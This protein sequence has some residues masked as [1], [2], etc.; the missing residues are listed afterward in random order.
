IYHPEAGATN[1]LQSYGHFISERMTY[2]GGFL[3]EYMNHSDV[4]F[5]NAMVHIQGEGDARMS[6][7]QPTENIMTGRNQLRLSNIDSL[8]VSTSSFTEHWARCGQVE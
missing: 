4:R 2:P 3:S 8:N 7:Q 1:Y 6:I 5:R